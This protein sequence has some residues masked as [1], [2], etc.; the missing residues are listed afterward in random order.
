MALRALS[1][2][3]LIAIAEQFRAL[4]EP[5]RLRLVSA[6]RGGEQ[7][8]TQLMDATGLGQANVSKHLRLLLQAGF[9]RRRKSGV[10]TYYRLADT[11]VS[12][13][14]D[15]MCDRLAADAAVRRK[16]FVR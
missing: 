4:A 8:V 7:S 1:S 6:L 10:M 5:S 11:D 16:V 9:V 3:Q 13:L 15:L 14:C 12:R 2:D